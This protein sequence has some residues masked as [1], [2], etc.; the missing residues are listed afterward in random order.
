[1]SRG[2]RC[3]WLFDESLRVPITRRRLA[4]STID[5][6]VPVR[7][8]RF[9]R[10]STPRARKTSTNRRCR[11]ERCEPRLALDAAL[12]SLAPDVLTALP[13]TAPVAAPVAAPANIVAPLANAS[14]AGRVHLTAPG[15]VANNA[16]PGVSG[17]TM[18]LMDEVGRVLQTAVTDAQGTYQFRGLS[19]G[20]YAVHQIQP[21][22]LVDGRIYVGT[23]GGQAITTNLLGEIVVAEGQQLTGYNFS[24]HTDLDAGGFFTAEGPP[25]VMLSS[26]TFTTGSLPVD[27][28][29]W[30]VAPGQGLGGVGRRDTATATGT[31]LWP[32]IPAEGPLLGAGTVEQDVA[33]KIPEPIF[34][35]SSRD[36]TSQSDRVLDESLVPALREVETDLEEHVA[37]A[38]ESESRVESE[39]ESEFGSE[40]EEDSAQREAPSAGAQTSEH[41]ARRVLIQGDSQEQPAKEAGEGQVESTAT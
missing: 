2:S 33:R 17:V 38:R 22:Q 29:L 6:G 20:T 26:G 9:P 12:A 10:Q 7:L 16:D 23:G 4:S 32:E 11:F 25:V 34:G 27:T 30:I 5:I 15:A 40:A 8:P 39:S 1:L 14:L 36:L 24:E 41:V 19:P 31:P 35:G 13:E 21:R 28:N 3:R 18:E 37:T